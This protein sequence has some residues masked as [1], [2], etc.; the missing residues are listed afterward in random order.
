MG[1]AMD[2]FILFTTTDEAEADMLAKKLEAT[3]RS[4]RA[5]SAAVTKRVHERL[6]ERKMLGEK[7][8]E[9]IV[10]GDP[11]WRPGLLGLVCN[12]VSEEYQRPVFLW[13]RE[14]SNILKGSCRAG[15]PD[16]NLLKLMQAAPPDTFIEFGGHRAS[17]GFSVQEDAIHSLEE[18]L[19]T[20]YASLSFAEF[21]EDERSDAELA[22]SAATP[23]FL[24]ALDRLAP[25][26]MGNPKPTFAMRN[27]IVQKVAWFGKSNEHLRLRIAP[28][29]ASTAGSANNMSDLESYF[30]STPNTSIE[31]ISFYAKRE[32]GTVCDALK[33]GDTKTLLV[34]LE[35]DTFS[36][37][38]P[39]RL[40]LISIA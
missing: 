26:G 36:R 10:M 35:R 13:G 33:E 3:N 19:N 12:S 30:S 11:E 17:G 9:V 31:G 24:R 38:Q 37:G 16:V 40:R 23:Q 21:E 27:V 25:F 2:A 29:A 22:I 39:V 32:L 20:A 4:R 15:R 34:T 5:S 18:R 28:G 6:E 14:G 1:D 7:I 8:P